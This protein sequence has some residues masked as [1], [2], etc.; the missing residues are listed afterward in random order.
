VL[1]TNLVQMVS[2][3]AQAAH[4]GC[5]SMVDDARALEA[6]STAI[7]HDCTQL[8]SALTGGSS[9]TVGGGVESLQ[10]SGLIEFCAGKGG[11][12]RHI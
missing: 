2:R 5:T 9:S 4:S 11:S 3:G 7:W 12:S 6:V 10:G 1:E 8:S